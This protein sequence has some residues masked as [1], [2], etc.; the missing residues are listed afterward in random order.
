MNQVLVSEVSNFMFLEIFYFWR[1]FIFGDFLF[2]SF[3]DFLRRVVILNFVNPYTPY[4]PVNKHSPHPTR[5]PS[6]PCPP[7]SRRPQ[8]FNT[9]HAALSLRHLIPINAFL[10]SN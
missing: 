8:S 10:T 9:H 4:P 6:S 7:G 3:S 5:T 2:F 1:F